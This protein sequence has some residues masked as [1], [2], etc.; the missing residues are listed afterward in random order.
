[1][2]LIYAIV[3]NTLPFGIGVAAS[4]RV[5]HLIGLRSSIG[6]RNAAHASALLSVIA[7]AVVMGLMI[8]SKN[9]GQKTIYCQFYNFYFRYLVSFSTMMFMLCYLSVK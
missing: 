9:V 1:M 5:G 7:G 4:T 8:A 3:L 2:S 6:A